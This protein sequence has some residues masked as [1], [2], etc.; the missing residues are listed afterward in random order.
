MV[1]T[2][3]TMIP[4][5][6]IILTNPHTH[7]HL[8]CS[9]NQQPSTKT[10]FV[11]LCYKLYTNNVFFGM[12]N[13]A[14][15]SLHPEIFRVPIRYRKFHAIV[16]TKQFPTRLFRASQNCFANNQ[17]NSTTWSLGYSDQW[18]NYQ[19]SAVRLENHRHSSPGETRVVVTLLASFDIFV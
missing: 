17:P 12:S 13:L 15:L 8:A 14:A 11:Y 1:R 9:W 10:T 2:H 7:T 3:P 18:P 5:I 19:Q 6:P 4:V 16:P